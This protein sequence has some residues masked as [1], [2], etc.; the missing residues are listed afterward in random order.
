MKPVV[1]DPPLAGMVAF[2]SGVTVT[3]APD[4][5]RNPPQIWLIVCPFGNAKASVQ[6]LTAVEV[7]LVMTISPWKLPVHWLMTVYRTVHETPGDDVVV[8]GRVVVVG[9]RVVVVGGRVVVV[10]GAV[11]VVGG[12]VVGG[13]V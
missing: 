13:T 7:L 11:V 9:G 6:P 4:W 3:F 8:G 10:G 12:T 2:Q 5:V 1:T